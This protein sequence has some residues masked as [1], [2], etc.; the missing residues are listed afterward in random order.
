[1]DLFMKSAKYTSTMYSYTA[2]SKRSS[3]VTSDEYS[4]AFGLSEVEYVGH[5]VE[6]VGHLVS[7]TGTSFTPE[8]RLKVHDFLQPTTQKEML[9][10]IGIAV[11]CMAQAANEGKWVVAK[12]CVVNSAYDRIW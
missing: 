8:K 4:S 2:N 6:Y 5:L 12:E 3:S 9:Q 1:M 7:A 11:A 10:F